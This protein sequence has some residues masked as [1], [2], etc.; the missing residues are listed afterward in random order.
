M[1][2][3]LARLPVEGPNLC[4]YCCRTATNRPIISA[5]HSFMSEMTTTTK[6]RK[7]TIRP[8]QRQGKSGSGSRKTTWTL[9]LLCRA[10]GFHRVFDEIRCNPKPIPCSK[11]RTPATG[12]SFRVRTVGCHRGLIMRPPSSQ[13]EHRSRVQFSWLRPRLTAKLDLEHRDRSPRFQYPHQSA[14]I[15]IQDNRQHDNGTD[16]DRLDVVVCTQKLQSRRKN[17]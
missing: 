15:A 7:R 16:D 8:A 14:A 12:F 13:L 9:Q 4:R 1:R 3:F 6:R 11:G 2:A 5:A 10:T 17:L